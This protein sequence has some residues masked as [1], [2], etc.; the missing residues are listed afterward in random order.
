M[1]VRLE[2]VEKRFGSEFAVKNMNLYIEDGD[3][4][5]LLGPSGCGKT[6]TLMMLAGVYRP[7]NGV[8]KFGDQVVNHLP[9][10]E[11]K[12]GM[13][14][15][16]YALYPHMTVFDNIAFPLTNKKMSRSEI[17]K[18]V[19]EAAEIVQIE[20]LLKRKPAE[21]SGGQQQRVSLARALVKEPELLLLDEPLS[22]LDA[23]LRMQM[24]SEIRRIQKELGFTAV[25]VTHDQTEAMTMAD[26]IAVM[27][28]GVLMA[29]GRPMDLY[30]KPDHRF[31]AEF[32][33]SPPINH[34]P[35]MLRQGKLLTQW[36]GEAIGLIGYPRHDDRS[37]TLSV[38]PEHLALTPDLNGDHN[39]VA[40]V[41]VIEALGYE[42]IYTLTY[43]PH[44][45][46][47][48]SHESVP[49]NE[50]QKVGVRID[51]EHVLYFD[52]EGRRIDFDM[53]ESAA[54]E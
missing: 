29:Y 37:F 20:K 4:V 41:T 46:R 6:T 36:S 24:R 45:L 21:L 15:Q 39:F 3:M 47:V 42:Y 53:I 35:V 32:L 48:R 22:N 54:G 17:K 9:P 13:V 38:R 5:V 12:I 31:V 11:R 14:F 30:N 40:N 26:K 8:I 49:V 34:I 51:W 33:G 25:L 27:K 19:H 10:Q 1:E 43:G 52:E 44:T 50:G 2:N 16:N 28:D 18:R 23:S 7:T